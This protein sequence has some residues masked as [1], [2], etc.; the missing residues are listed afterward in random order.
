MRGSRF[1]LAYSGHG[2]RITSL[3]K[4][5]CS[6]TETQK[7]PN[8]PSQQLTEAPLPR[9]APKGPALKE[10]HK[11][12]L[13]LGSLKIG[14]KKKGENTLGLILCYSEAGGTLCR[15]MEVRRKA[16]DL[17]GKLSS[18]DLDALM[19]CCQGEPDKGAC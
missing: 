7:Q 11:T 19:R 17:V 12:K 18:L 16:Q 13:K 1:H 10:V 9:T 5:T 8:H 3:S 4:E 14:G 6:K 15:N 2:C